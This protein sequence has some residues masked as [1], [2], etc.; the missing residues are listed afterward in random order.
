MVC[1]T[2]ALVV[3]M[4]TGLCSA[5]ILVPAPAAV[6]PFVAVCCVGLPI[7]A[8]WRVPVAVDALRNRPKQLTERS[9]AALRRELA[10]LPETEHPLGE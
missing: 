5:A 9:L 1:I 3:L 2:A 7:L 8:G 10:R 4:G 6:V